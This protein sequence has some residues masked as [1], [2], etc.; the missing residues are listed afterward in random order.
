M[1]KKYQEQIF[2]YFYNKK[3]LIQV[4]K[5]IK[6]MTGPIMILIKIKKN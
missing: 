4:I 5:K 1:N 6:N 2:N 3:Q